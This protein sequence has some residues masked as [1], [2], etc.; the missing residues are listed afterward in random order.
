M[1][2]AIRLA[3]AAD[4]RGLAELHVG[5]WRWGYRDLLPG[6]YLAALSVDAREQS[7]R[8]RLGD[9]A[10][11]DRTLVWCEG[12]RARGF[13]S[14]GPARGDEPGP[15]GQ[16]KL[17]ALYLEEALAGRGVGRALHDAAIEAMRAAGFAAVVL[18]VLEDNARA[19]AFYA[20]QGW[21]PDGHRKRDAYGDA[22]RDGIRLALRLA[23]R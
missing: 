12:G 7:W 2:D 23:P 22:H 10:A 11:L 16:A 20:R 19:C 3:A 17:H 5:G 6:A 13:V 9:P 15:A 14:F 18:W 1:I 4:A 21:A 8:A